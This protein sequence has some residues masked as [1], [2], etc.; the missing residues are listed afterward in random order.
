MTGVAAEG[1]GNSVTHF[2]LLVLEN[3]AGRFFAVVEPSKFGPRQLGQ[4]C[5][6]T[7]S[8]EL[9]N[10]MVLPTKR[11]DD[12]MSCEFRRCHSFGNSIY[13]Q[14]VLSGA[15]ADAEGNTLD[16]FTAEAV[17]ETL[18]DFLALVT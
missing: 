15:S 16:Q 3:S 5:A 6:V 13:C 1:P 12:F 17:L 11:W 2:T 18:K 4:F 7:V 14:P 10:I 8:N 9:S